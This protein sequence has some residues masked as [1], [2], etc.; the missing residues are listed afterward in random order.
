M[1]S[2]VKANNFRLVLLLFFFF[3]PPTHL[4]KP[5]RGG[6]DSLSLLRCVK[7]GVAAQSRDYAILPVSEPKLLRKT[8]NMQQS[9]SLHAASSAASAVER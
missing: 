3:P 8:D 2:V 4:G 7:E 5:F 1:S 9:G 6:I